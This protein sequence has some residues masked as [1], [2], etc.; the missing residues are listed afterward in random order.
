MRKATPK[1]KAKK[2]RT[3]RIYRSV[4][5]WWEDAVAR[6]SQLNY[7]SHQQRIDYKGEGPWYRQVSVIA[8]YS[9]YLLSPNRAYDDVTRS[10][11]THALRAIL[12]LNTVYSFVRFRNEQGQIVHGQRISF[13]RFDSY[14]HYR[15]FTTQDH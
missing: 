14:E 6:G 5:R 2:Q 9:D 11:F 12:R 13:C 3:S 7:G 15:E 1:Y 4:A 10:E 8:L